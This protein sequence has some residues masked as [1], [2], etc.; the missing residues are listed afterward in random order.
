M[1]TWPKVMFIGSNILTLTVLHIF[2]I[3]K[4]DLDFWL[5]KVI[6]GQIW[7]CQKS[8]LASN[9][10]SV[11]VL[12]TLRI[13][14]LWPWTLT[15]Q[16]HPK[17]SPWPVSIISVRSNIVTLSVLDIFHIRKYDLDFWP[18]KVI[19]GQ[20]WRC[21]WKPVVSTRISNRFRGISSQ[22]ILTLT[23]DPS[24]SS[25]VKSDGANL[26]PIGTFLYDVCWV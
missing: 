24:G 19:Q 13:K 1:S 15:S 12:K 8:S 10:V 2:H 25:K 22:R 18:F 26:K 4:Y 20:M 23:F 3:R 16:G 14:W 17:W 6:Q 11:T 9:L 7:L 5:L 21:N